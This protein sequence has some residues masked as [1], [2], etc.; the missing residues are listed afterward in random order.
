VNPAANVTRRGETVAVGEIIHDGDTFNFGE[1]GIR[2]R[3]A[4]S[5]Q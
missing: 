2:L 3:L 5:R 4:L 1:T